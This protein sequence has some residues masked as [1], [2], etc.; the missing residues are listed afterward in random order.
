MGEKILDK[1]TYIGLAEIRL[2]A[3]CGIDEVEVIKPHTIGILSIGNEIKNVK[4]TIDSIDREYILKLKQSYD[5]KE[6]ALITLLMQKGFDALYF[7]I[8]DV[9]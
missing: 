5:S 7:G 9:E 2:L 3:S 6:L 4:D 8:V 1:Y